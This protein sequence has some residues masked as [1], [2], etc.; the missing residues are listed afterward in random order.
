MGRGWSM[1]GGLAG[2]RVGAETW[3]E[4][5]ERAGEWAAEAWAAGWISI[6][7]KSWDYYGFFLGFSF[8]Q[9]CSKLAMTV[10]EYSRLPMNVSILLL[11]IIYRL[12]EEQSSNLT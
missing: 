1:G 10:L 8:L 9:D 4:E 7:K 12:S 6:L 3:A 2:E 5:L 11:F